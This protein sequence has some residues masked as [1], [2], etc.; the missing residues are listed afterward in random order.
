MGWKGLIKM[1]DVH[2]FYRIIFALLISYTTY[3]GTSFASLRYPGCSFVGF[4]ENDENHTKYYTI[5]A[6]K[7]FF[8]TIISVQPFYQRKSI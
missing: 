8:L 4:A 6:L 5:S 2:V 7:A 3:I 1:V